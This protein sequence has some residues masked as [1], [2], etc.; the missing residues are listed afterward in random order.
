M[1]L[2]RLQSFD[3]FKIYIIVKRVLRFTISVRP[4]SLRVQIVNDERKFGHACDSVDVVA[5]ARPEQRNY[6][7][8]IQNR[9]ISFKR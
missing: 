4:D 1:K 6:T 3:I 9:F 5:F 2:N 7:K 8:T